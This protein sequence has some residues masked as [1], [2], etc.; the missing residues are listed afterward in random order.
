V[1]DAFRHMRSFFSLMLAAIVVLFLFSMMGSW[2]IPLARPICSLK[3]V[4]P[5]VPFCHPEA[6]TAH[7]THTTAGQ[8]ARWADY[9]SLISLQ[10]R[11]FDRL[12]NENVG[13][14][15]LA[16]DVAKAEI[17]NNDLITLVK[18]SDLKSKN[19]IAQMLSKFSDDAREAGE[20]LHS[21][22]AK[23]NG[24]VDSIMTLNDHALQ[25]L[26]AS[27]APPSL[28][29]RVLF[30]LSNSHPTDEV[31]LET[32]LMSMDHVG[33]ELTYLREEADESRIH[34]VGLQRHLNNIHTIVSLDD[35]GLKKAKEEVLVTLWTQLGGNRRELMEMNNSLD[36]LKNVGKYR[37][38]A[39]VHVVATLETLRALKADI[40]ELRR[41]VGTPKLAGVKLPIDIQIQSIKAGMER[42]KEGQMRASLTQGERVKRMME[43]EG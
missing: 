40:V 34:L 22:W 6:P 39:L 27:K 5:M 18:L 37:E 2:L 41:R 4:S 33:N 21:L 31:V 43:K 3:I 26:E 20:S 8:A 19:R 29:D 23:I 10:T 13:S 38:R 35:K 25:T 17:A 9:P 11:T 14:K 36:V 32:F 1:G 12:L 42:L 28:V 15:G 30:S 7:S 24:A 16:L